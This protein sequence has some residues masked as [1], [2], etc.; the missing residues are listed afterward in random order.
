MNKFIVIMLT[1]LVLTVIGVQSALA[2][3]TMVCVKWGPQGCEVWE[4]RGS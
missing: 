1:F 2:T 3:Y 4:K